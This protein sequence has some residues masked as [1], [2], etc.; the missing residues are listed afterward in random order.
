MFFLHFH[1]RSWLTLLNVINSNLLTFQNVEV[2]KDA[3]NYI[4]YIIDC[5]PFL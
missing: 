2:K 3:S 5:H 1:T 4:Y